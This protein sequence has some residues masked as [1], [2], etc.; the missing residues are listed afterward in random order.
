MEEISWKQKSR[1][2][3]LKE[4]DKCM[5]FFHR[6]ANSHRRNNAIDTMVDGVVSLDQVSIKDPIA[7]YYEHLLAEQQPWRPKLD[8]LSFSAIDQQSIGRLERPFD[9]EVHTVIRDMASN[10]APGPDHGLFPN[11]LGGDQ[12]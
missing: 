1:T 3:W 10:K 9:E 2:L 5:E 8:G 12:G 7:Q 6:V 4:G 11:L